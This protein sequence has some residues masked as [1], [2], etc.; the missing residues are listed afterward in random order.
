MICY[1]S[2]LYKTDNIQDKFT[3]VAV[4]EGLLEGWDWLLN[5]QAVLPNLMVWGW[6][7]YYLYGDS[8]LGW[9]DPL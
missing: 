5:S 7:D 6:S 3:H 8:E 9:E 2:L 4:I 1:P